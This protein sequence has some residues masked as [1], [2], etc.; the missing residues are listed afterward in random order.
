MKLVTFNIRCDWDQDGKNSFRFRKELIRRKVEQEKPDVLCFQEVLPH[1]A[2][3]LREN[4]QGYYVIGC[5]RDER[6][7]NEQ[8]PIAFRADTFS[9]L[10][11]E[12]YWLSETPYVPGSRYKEQSDCP[13][14][15]T[16]AVLM[17]RKTGHVFR[18]VNVH[19]D[20]IGAYARQIGLRQILHHLDEAKFCP[21]APCVIT[22]DFNCYPGGPEIQEM[23]AYPDYQNFTR[24]IGMTFHNFQGNAFCDPDD[25]HASMRK[26][27]IDYIFAKGHFIC[28]SVCKWTDEENG[29]FL[30]DHFPVC[31]EMH[32]Q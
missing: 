13:R 15:C 1:V 9:L 26:G 8:L 24:D 5:G 7:G 21:D 12:T 22:G 10:E 31:A 29:V 32:W 28:N 27:N 2:D 4:L 11:M 19:L 6:L 23:N 20:H 3:W 14:V 16:Q 18:L 30:S 17:E 25:P